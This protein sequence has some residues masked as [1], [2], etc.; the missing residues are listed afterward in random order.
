MVHGDARES[1]LTPCTEEDRQKIARWL[2]V[3]YG[4]ENVKAE[5]PDVSERQDLWWLFLLGVILLLCGE[6]CWTR[7]MVRRRTVVSTN[8]G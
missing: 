6:V 2:P 4:L 5:V 8:E 1:D 7:R 3:I